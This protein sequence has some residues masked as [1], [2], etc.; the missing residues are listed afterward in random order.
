MCCCLRMF[1]VWKEL[2]F[3]RAI[4]STHFS[5]KSVARYLA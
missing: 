4:T 5:A 1:H 3:M 2:E